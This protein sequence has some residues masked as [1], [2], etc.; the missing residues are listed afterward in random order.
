MLYSDHCMKV[1][2]L[3]R[4]PHFSKNIVGATLT[5]ASN[6]N[7]QCLIPPPRTEVHMAYTNGLQIDMSV[8]FM[9]NECIDIEKERRYGVF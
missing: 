8:P 4:Y 6:Y 9:K 1:Q 5:G 3:D 2:R 7:A